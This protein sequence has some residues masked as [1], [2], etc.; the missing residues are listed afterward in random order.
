MPVQPGTI[1]LF[2]TRQSWSSKESS[3][4]RE[5]DAYAPMNKLLVPCR[6][7]DWYKESASLHELEAFA[8]REE[9]P[10]S[11]ISCLTN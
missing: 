2:L 4:L 10:S 6:L 9:S 11:H 1:S 5:L 3:S 7:S 8:T